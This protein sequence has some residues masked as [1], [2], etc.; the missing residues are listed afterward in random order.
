[1]FSV[2][3]IAYGW[4]VFQAPAETNFAGRRPL[5]V[6]KESAQTSRAGACSRRGRT[7]LS[8]PSPVGKVSTKLTDEGL[9]AVGI[10]MRNVLLTSVPHQSP[11][12]PASPTGK[13]RDEP[14]PTENAENPHLIV[15]ATIGRPHL[16]PRQAGGRWPPLRKSGRCLHTL[17]FPPAQ[18]KPPAG[19]FFWFGQFKRSV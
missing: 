18:K 6:C 16:H 7:A 4:H 19:G 13:P 8:K 15:G 17:R 9:Q 2:G 12:A 11:T 14:T 3:I 10:A 5:P 1:M